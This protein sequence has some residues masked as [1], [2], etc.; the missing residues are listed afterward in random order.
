MSRPFEWSPRKRWPWGWT[1]ESE[2]WDLRDAR[3]CIGLES[4][5]RTAMVFP[6]GGRR[7]APFWR[8]WFV[9]DYAA[10][11]QAATVP[12]RPAGCDV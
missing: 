10:L 6:S 7:R 12:A 9:I 5:P 2:R 11:L 4:P 1:G 3:P 8:Y